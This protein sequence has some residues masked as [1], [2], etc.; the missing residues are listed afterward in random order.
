MP[1]EPAGDGVASLVVR[2]RLRACTRRLGADQ[3][4]HSSTEMLA[5][6]TGPPRTRF[7][8][9]ERTC[10]FF[11]RPATTRSIAASKCSMPTAAALRRPAIKAAVERGEHKERARLSQ[12]HLGT[13]RT[14]P[15]ARAHTQTRTFV[16]HVGNVGAGEAGRQV[17]NLFGDLG[18]GRRQLDV[19]QV[20]LEDLDAAAH[21]RPVDRDL[22]V[23][24]GRR[25]VGER[26]RGLAKR[27]ATLRRNP[28]S[29]RWLAHRSGQAGGGRGPAHRHGW[30]RPGRSRRS[31]DRTRPSA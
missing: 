30:C 10:V 9:G 20:H 23:C 12:L 8:S 31:R 22:A 5:E 6:T 24:G 7:S 28:R 21:V 4:A 17:R 15:H 13:L 2:H 27:D 16:A 29:S 25:R 14:P 19:A 11:S 3:S 26:G 1:Q 18:R